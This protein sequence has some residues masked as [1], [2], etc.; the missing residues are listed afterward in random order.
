MDTDFRVSQ[1]N[2][3]NAAKKVMAI[4]KVKSHTMR[5][6]KV[7][8]DYDL[9]PIIVATQ[10]R[11]ETT[12]RGAETRSLTRPISAVISLAGAIKPPGMQPFKGKIKSSLKDCSDKGPVPPPETSS[13]SPNKGKHASNK[14]SFKRALPK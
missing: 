12:M 7:S 8:D 6:S 2:K 10:E 3:T 4:M 9:M 14:S 13:S 5:F 1:S 11:H